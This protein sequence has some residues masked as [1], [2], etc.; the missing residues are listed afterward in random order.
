MKR[1]TFITCL[2]ALLGG[3][4]GICAQ[5][6]PKMPLPVKEH[7]WLK[8]FSGEWESTSEVIF[9]PGKPAVKGTSTESARM[10]GGFWV[11]SEG[12]GEMMG[13]TMSSILTLGYD[14]ESKKYIGTWVDSLSGHLWK[15]EG[16]V[17]STGKILTLETE[18]PCPKKPGQLS[19]FRDVTEFKSKDHRISTSSIL[20]D[21]GK[22]ETTVT[23]HSHRR[24]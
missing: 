11:I 15:Y 24:K 16:T 14:A 22:W 23:V 21:D 8:Q 4:A 9:E 17:D 19:K 1:I 5:E 12:K 7:E 18:G 20:G 3:A 6:M 2:V 13:M 10:L